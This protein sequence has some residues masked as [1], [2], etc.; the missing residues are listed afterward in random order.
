MEPGYD[1]GEAGMRENSE[2]Q[3]QQNIGSEM[4]R[5]SGL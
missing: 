1:G 5:I 4:R 3:N 2:A